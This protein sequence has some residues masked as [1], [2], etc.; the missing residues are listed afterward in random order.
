MSVSLAPVSTPH[1]SDQVVFPKISPS[2][3]SMTSTNGRPNS[4]TVSTKPRRC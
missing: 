1:T 4:V 2:A 3:C